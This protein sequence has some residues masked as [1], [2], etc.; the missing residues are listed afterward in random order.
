LCGVVGGVCIFGCNMVVVHAG[1]GGGVLDAGIWISACL[2]SG[3]VVFGGY[4]AFVVA[5]EVVCDGGGGVVVFCRHFRLLS[6]FPAK[7]GQAF[8]PA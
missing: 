5:G 3:G 7:F 2:G 8:F 4:S 6:V 1:I